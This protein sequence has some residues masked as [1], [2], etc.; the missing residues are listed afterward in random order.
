MKELTTEH[1]LNTWENENR[2][3]EIT[4]TEQMEEGSQN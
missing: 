2:T 4:S 1:V 3:G